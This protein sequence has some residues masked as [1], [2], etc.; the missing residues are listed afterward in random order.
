MRRRSA[1]ASSLAASPSR[2]RASSG[3]FTP[4]I[5]GGVARGRRPRSSRSTCLDR[6]ARGPAA[7]GRAPA[8]C[9]R[10]ASSR[11]SRSRWAPTRVFGGGWRVR[12]VA[13]RRGARDDRHRHDD[14]RPRG[15]DAHGDD[16]LLP[17]GRARADQQLR[18]HRR[19]AARARAPRR[20]HPRGV[21]RRHARGARLRGA[22]HA[23]RPAAGAG[24]GARA[25]LDRLHPRH[26]AGLPQADDRAARRVRRADVRGALRRRALRARAAARDHRRAAIPT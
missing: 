19:R 3:S 6:L 11:A 16:R 21:V 1:A 18:R 2:R 5:V 24:G 7:D 10:P 17:G 14:R 12:R 26:G 15:P 13:A 8:S 9:S 23:P 20:L 4:A 25:V 22:A